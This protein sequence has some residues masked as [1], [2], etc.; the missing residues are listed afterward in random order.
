MT[1]MS[2]QR[3]RERRLA[4]QN[5]KNKICQ[6]EKYEFFSN[7][8]QNAQTNVKSYFDKPNGSYPDF[9]HFPDSLDLI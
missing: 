9:Q 8:Y 5:K 1:P 4:I 6:N 2:P 3:L 7:K